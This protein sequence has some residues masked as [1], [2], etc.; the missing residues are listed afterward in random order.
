MGEDRQ[1]GY[2]SD[3]KIQAPQ[4]HIEGLLTKVGSRTGKEETNGLMSK[5]KV[6]H[7]EKLEKMFQAKRR[8]YIMA[9]R[10]G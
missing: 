3:G 9:Q 10:G 7:M 1:K 4:K 5:D 2:D 8:T 6:F